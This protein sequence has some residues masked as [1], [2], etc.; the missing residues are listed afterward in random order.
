MEERRGKMDRKKF[1]AALVALLTGVVLSAGS[2]SAQYGYLMG[3]PSTGK[4]I[5]AYRTGANTA[6][7]IG[8][9]ST[10]GGS[11]G[12]NVGEGDL[13]V[14]VTVF[15]KRSQ[16]VLNFD[17]CLSPSDFGF[18]VLQATGPNAQQ[19]EELNK[20]FHKVRILSVAA[21]NIP[22]EGYVTM[23]ITAEF[24]SNDGKC[25]N[26]ESD[27][28]PTYP[29]TVDVLVNHNNEEHL[30]TWAILLDVGQGFFAAEIPTVT[31]NIDPVSGA[32]HGG[33]GAYG[34][35]PG[36]P[37]DPSGCAN[38]FDEF[39][40]VLSPQPSSHVIARFDVNPSVDSHTDIFV[41][42]QRNSTIVPGDPGS[43]VTR[44]GTFTGFLDCEDEFRVSTTLSL[45]DELNVIDPD[46]L[47]GINQCKAVDQFR[48]NLL[49]AMPDT[50]FV[51]SQITQ[52]GAHFREN[53]LGY[54]LG[55][56]DFIDCADGFQDFFNSCDTS[57]LTLC[58]GNQPAGTCD[59]P[60]KM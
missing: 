38:P 50:G 22:V 25:N 15:T 41:W 54:N 53:Y 30:A 29:P 34:L 56:N 35:I 1:G 60:P 26:V 20:R 45:P 19:Q 48:G 39:P 21:D 7:V 32:A 52:E 5:P 44:T 8:F 57:S 40:C 12:P 10:E 27:E 33:I 14:H 13:S 24:E 28:F 17:L 58:G 47:P 46:T 31:A 4:L 42:L 37:L 49:F 2:A 3:D 36:P 43:G 11:L 51:W 16:E 9:T 23:V 59:S 18:I 6:T 55:D